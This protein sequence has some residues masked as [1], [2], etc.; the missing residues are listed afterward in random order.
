MLQ[1]VRKQ[2]LSIHRLKRS[3]PMNAITKKRAETKHEAFLRLANNRMERALE[4]MRLIGQLSSR[5]YEN[6]LEEAEGIV[7]HLAQGIHEI[8]RQFGVA[9]STAVGEEAAANAEATKHLI[10]A[11]KT[12][13]S[14][15]E[16]DVAQA[17]DLI[18]RGE[19]EAAIGTLKAALKGDKR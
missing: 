13:G 3:N 16:L 2:N 9:F 18:R 11:S 1:T 14:I 7:Y 4:D 12:G 17:I 10:T 5:T 15:N 6:T 19:G 8:S